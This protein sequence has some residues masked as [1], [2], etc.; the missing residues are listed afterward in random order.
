MGGHEK[1]ALFGLAASLAR[2]GRSYV[3][4]TVVRREGLTSAHQGDMAIVTDT[5]EFYGW[6]GGGCTRPTVEREAIRVLAQ[7]EPRLVV[8]SPEPMRDPRPGVLALPMT[9]HSGGTVEIYLDPVV[10]APRL[11]LFGRSPIVTALAALAHGIGYLVDVA[12]PDAQADEVPG[13]DRVFTSIDAPELAGATFAVAG[14]MGDFDEEAVVR[15]LGLGASYVGVIASRRR[16]ALLRDAVAA[17][18]VAAD[19]LAM[20]VNPAGL[21]LGA[22]EPGE[23]AVSVLAQIVAR[24]NAVAR[25]A[26][27][28]AAASAVA[29]APRRS[30]P[31]VARVAPAVESAIDPVCKMTVDVATAKHV[32]EW[33]GRSWYFCCGGCK[34]KFLAQPAQFLGPGAG[35]EAG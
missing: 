34:T 32:A 23:V 5:G 27:P 29:P 8:L 14:T 21:D 22:R 26:E 31:L 2:S 1:R 17:R 35:A 28:D 7:R 18:G 3:V 11:V 4:A 12:D 16:Y 25:V 9:C 19:A 6:I 30:L 13:A 33:G 24:R 10:A 15:A 20:I